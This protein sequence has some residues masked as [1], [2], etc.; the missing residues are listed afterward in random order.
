MHLGI[1]VFMGLWLFSAVMIVLNVS[2]FGSDW[3]GA[4]ARPGEV[5]KTSAR[6]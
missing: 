4:F 2:A 5:A 6:P 3:V 1:G